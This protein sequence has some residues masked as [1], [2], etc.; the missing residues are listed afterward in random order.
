MHPLNPPDRFHVEAARGWLELGNHQEANEELDRITAVNRAHLE[1]LRVRWRIYAKA[2]KWDA[3]LDTAQALKAMEPNHRFG[4]IHE[5]HSLDRLG[6]G[7]EA[8]ES[9]LAAIEHFG[10]NPTFAFHLACLAARMGQLDEARVWVREAI[11][12][13]EDQKTLD[14]LRLRILDEPALEAIWTELQGG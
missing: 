5:A 14:R 1:V 6:Q 11:D 13:A 10:P 9:I 8:K 3:C 2:G 4:W 7:D 12:L